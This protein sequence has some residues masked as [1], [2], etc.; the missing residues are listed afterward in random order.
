MAR[1]SKHPPSFDVQ[2]VRDA[3][4]GRW[5]EILSSLCSIDRETLDGNHHPCPKCGGHDRFRMIDADAGA[6]LC[7]QCFSDKNGDGFAAVQWARD[8]KFGQALR[9]VAEYLGVEPSSNGH[10]GKRSKST[11]NPTEHLRFLPWSDPLATLWCALHKPGITPGAM[12]TAH[13]RLA[14][15]RDQYTV[16]AFPHW[17]PKLTAA[18]PIGWTLYNVSGGKLPKYD[19]ATKTTAW[20]KV[21]VTRGSQSG[22]IGPVERLAD[23][24][25]VWKTEGPTDLLALLSLDLPA[26]TVAITNANGA[27]ERPAP[28]MLDLFTGKF[29]R[30]IHDADRP[31][32]QGAAGW[33]KESGE[34]RPGWCESIAPHATEVRHVRLPFPIVDDH[35]RDLR[36]WINEPD[37][38]AYADLLALSAASSITPKPASGPTYSALEADDDPH[39]LARVNLE[40]YASHTAQATLRYWRDEWYTWKPSRG[41]YRRIGKEELRAKVGAAIKNEFNRINVEKQQEPDGDGDIPNAQK[42]TKTLIT[43]VLEATASM[44][45]VPSSVEMMTWLDGKQ[46]ERRNYVAMAN[47]ILDLDRLLNDPAAEL[48]DVLLPHSPAWF[49]CVRLPYNFDPDAKCPKWEKFLE[50]NLEMDPERIK[51]L[52]EWAGYM[53]LP[54]TGQQKFLVLEGEGANGKSVYCAAIS[55]MLGLEN[56]SHIPLEQFGDRF[57][58][59]QTLGK[60]ANICADTGE[61]DRVAEG[62]LKSFTSGD[63]MYFDRKG[64]SGIDCTPTARLMLACNNRPRLSDR[65]SGIWRRMLLVP[66]LVQ[67]TQSER[68][69]NMD[70]HW[71]WEVS[72]ELPGILLWAI[73]GLHRLRQQSRFTHSG[74]S[75]EAINDYRAES[76][77]ARAYLFECLEMREESKV[78]TSTIYKFYRAWSE[79]NGYRSMGERTFGKEIVRTF[80]TAERKRGGTRGDRYWYYEGLGFSQDEIAG[81]STAEQTLF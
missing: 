41:C 14:R 40:R 27:A 28:W 69:A 24:S 19:K 43:N 15:Y 72:G 1:K 60:L 39:R 54:D 47:G 16:F 22:L 37:P 31:G 67:I 56:C 6:L 44:V 71:W 12:V 34:R 25:T 17:G 45:L 32:D 7:N 76:N 4:R 30:V 50:R 48:A 53:L 57:A 63:V 59:T 13:C 35:G 46:R 9:S 68:V 65:S 81:E 8:M 58:K 51:I 70:K 61:I 73:R 23:A 62:Y 29:A 11:G 64:I 52:Q 66:F 36:D 78:R 5:A 49:S 20:V 42:V 38:H 26:D 74:M 33:D 80:P 3:A 55:A 2:L 79:L 75:E 21:K 10:A 77:P 18:E